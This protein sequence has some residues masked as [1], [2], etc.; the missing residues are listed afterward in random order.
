MYGLAVW[1]LIASARYAIDPPRPVSPPPAKVEVADLAAEGYASL[2]ARRY[3]TWNANDPEAYRQ[4]LEPFLGSNTNATVGVELPRSGSQQ[5]Q[6]TQVVQSREPQT[7]EHVYTVAAQTDASGLLYLT[8]NVI[9]KAGGILALAGYPAFVGAPASTTIDN[10]VEH[11]HS[12]EEPVL[13]TVIKRA[14]H[15]YLAAS[16]SDLAADLTSEAQVSLPGM[17]LALQS[18]GQM[19]WLPGHASVFAVL[20]ASDS[21]G[22]LYTLTYEL[23]V[24]HVQ[25]RWEISAIQMNPDT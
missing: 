16:A 4:E 12:V 8:V 10:L 18:V 2:F 3:L 23:D 14:L 15:N 21:R 1:G 22:A 9:R 17:E 25:G 7:G 13:E 19:K 5:V 20:T 11:L 6:W 24:S